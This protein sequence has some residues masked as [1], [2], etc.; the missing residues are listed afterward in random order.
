MAKPRRTDLYRK[1]LYHITQNADNA[2]SDVL[3]NSHKIGLPN[4]MSRSDAVCLSV[5]EMA[6]LIEYE[7]NNPGSVPFRYKMG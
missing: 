7:R 5:T 2:V 4:C 3:G 6:Y 1:A